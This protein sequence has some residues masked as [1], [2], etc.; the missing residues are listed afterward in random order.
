M[1]ACRGTPLALMRIAKRISVGIKEAR[2]VGPRYGERAR[3]RARP[4]DRAIRINASGFRCRFSLW[5][6]RTPGVRAQRLTSSPMTH[7]SS[8]VLS[9]HFVSVMR[10]L[11]SKVQPI[12]SWSVSLSVRG[13]SKKYMRCQWKS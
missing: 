9:P 1:L 5:T 4:K 3:H 10:E 11:V 2:G 8:W 12:F 13:L 6:H 7:I